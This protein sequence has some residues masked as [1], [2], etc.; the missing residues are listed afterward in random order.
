[1]KTIGTCKNCAH[2]GAARGALNRPEVGAK[3]CGHPK[4]D[5]ETRRSRDGAESWM[6][7]PQ[8]LMV[9]PEFGCIH[10]FP[11]GPPPPLPT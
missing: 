1:M 11:H 7:T 10:W 6:D 5:G 9:G 8:S 4:L 3:E 2:W